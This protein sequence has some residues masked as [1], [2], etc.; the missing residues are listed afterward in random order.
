MLALKMG[1][2]ASFDRNLV[3]K[4]HKIENLKSFPL[5]L[6]DSIN[7]ISKTKE[8][9]KVLKKFGLD[10]EL[11]R[12]KEK[13]VRA[14][15]GK[16]RGRKYKKKLGIVFVSYDAEKLNKILNNLNIIV[17]SPNELKVSD[18]S[19]AGEPGRLIIWSKKALEGLNI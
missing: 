14:G 19:Q 17:K 4:F 15:K 9:E 16:L 6:D 3:S 8:A 11:E 1:I 13:K 7:S 10:Q 12:I 18:V 2:M 5:V